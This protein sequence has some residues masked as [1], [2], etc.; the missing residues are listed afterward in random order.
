MRCSRWLAA[1]DAA[2]GVA[3][4]EGDRRAEAEKLLV[5]LQSEEAIQKAIATYGA[6]SAQVARLRSDAERQAFEATV[7]SLVPAGDL[8]DRLMA[9]WENA[10]GLA[11]TDAAAGLARARAEAT[12]IADEL[13]RA[14]G[15][16]QSLA[17][18]GAGAAQDAEL[19]WK[20]RK[21]PVALAG[22]LAN[23]KF[24]RD[25][26]VPL[27][28]EDRTLARIEA[29]RARSVGTAR[30]A[31]ES[32]EKLSAWQRAQNKGGKGGGAGG[33]TLKGLSKEA[34]EILAELDVASGAIAVKVKAGMVTVAEGQTELAGAKDQA[35]QR[36]AE[37]I[38]RLDR[39]GP[40]GKAAADAARKSLT[41][42]ASEASKA[43]DTVRKSLV[44]SFDENF[45]RSL[46]TGKNAMTAFADH[47]QMELARAFTKKFITPLISPL[48][49]GLVN[50]FPFAE[51]GV[52]DAPGLAMHRNTVVDRPTPFAMAGGDM[53]DMGDMGEAGPEA[54]L[55]LLRGAGGLGVRAIGAG[56]AERILPLQRASG[57]ALGVALPDM[58]DVGAILRRP[59]FFASGGVVGRLSSAP[60]M[61]EA[62]SGSGFGRGAAPRITIN[63]NHSGARVEASE[64]ED[65]NGWFVDIFIDQVE[66][67]NRANR[68]HGANGDDPDQPADLRLPWRHD[69][70]V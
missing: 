20:Y 17:S 18:Q 53:G 4:L 44:D 60:L 36:L 39:L 70:D 41:D 27:D 50:M 26:K 43:G 22:V 6:E 9:A 49:G 21:D 55:P 66:N 5:Q 31:A 3:K 23:A 15:N 37:L 7:A 30:A 29:D 2:K 40:A 67:A 24:D 57:G 25:V 32:Q 47:V 28:A 59:T 1:W 33:G 52:P 16:A 42:L 51:G 10:G 48:I 35:A 45:A 69:V 14:L 12:A 58:P 34:R 64:R 68:T 54:I 11:G 62:T 56:G 19:R 13:G 61:G 65:S 63:N 8:R 46:A 38:A